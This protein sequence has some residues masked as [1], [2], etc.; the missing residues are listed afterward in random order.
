M[1]VHSSQQRGKSRSLLRFL[2]KGSPRR[3]E[4]LLEG[5]ESEEEMITTSPV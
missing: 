2:E 5:Q 1:Q 3:G 4:A